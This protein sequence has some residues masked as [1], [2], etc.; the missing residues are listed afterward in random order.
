MIPA[1]RLL[2]VLALGTLIGRSVGHRKGLEVMQTNGLIGL[3]A[4]GFQEFA[5]TLRSPLWLS[6]FVI[7]AAGLFALAVL[8]RDGIT[9]PNSRLAASIVASATCGA[10]VGAGHSLAAIGIGLAAAVTI[11]AASV[12]QSS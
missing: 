9:T 2:V 3:G 1:I 4:A 11:A 5:P 8:V 6:P 7:G 12:G 10:A